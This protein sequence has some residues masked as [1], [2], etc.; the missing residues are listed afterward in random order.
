MAAAHRPFIASTSTGST[1]RKQG[2][3]IGL[4]FS[5]RVVTEHGGSLPIGVS[6]WGG[7]EFRI[8]LPLKRA[9][10]AA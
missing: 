9:G 2:Y 4:S 1:T 8:E 7:A 5:H 3:G 6:R 10:T